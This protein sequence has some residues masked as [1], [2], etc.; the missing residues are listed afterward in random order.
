MKYSGP[1]CYQLF[2]AGEEDKRI[3]TKKEC[4][5]K[6][7]KFKKPVT[8]N[9]TPKIYILKRE[10][11]IVYVG[12]AS[13]SIGTRLGQGIRATGLNGYHG[14]KWKQIDELE[15]LVF[16][17]DQELNGSKHKDDIPYVLLAEAVEAELVF[18]FRKENGQWPE[19]QNEIHFNNEERDLAKKIAED[20]Y[21][22]VTHLET[23]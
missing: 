22:Q 7:T 1:Y 15:L 13:L 8:L 5:G 23:A 18:K 6:S 21:Q 3:I 9:K 11:K 14:Y 19:F 2:L 16:V 17:F 20:M 4:D 12:Y 10:G